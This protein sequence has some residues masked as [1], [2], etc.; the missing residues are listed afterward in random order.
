NKHGQSLKLLDKAIAIEPKEALFH[1]AKGDIFFNRKQFDYAL[2]AYDRAIYL[3]DNYFYFYEKR[4]LIHKQLGNHA[5]A[6]Q[7]LK[8]S[9]DLL[10]TAIAYNELGQFALKSG[11][12]S[13]AKHF[14]IKAASSNSRA[15]KS[16]LHS[17]TKLD[18]PDNPQKYVQV[19]WKENNKNDAVFKIYNLSP[20]PLYNISL[21]INFH[22]DKGE[23]YYLPI[24]LPDV[25]APKKNVLFSIDDQTIGAKYQH[26]I[27]IDVISAQA[28][29]QR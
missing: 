11:D 25:I 6:I 16:A 9:S 23:R 8:R 24:H 10:P 14:F 18:I 15:G 3:N 29:T 1:G 22:N 5:N 13:G 26:T 2:N 4:G 27:T 17:Y 28:V 19:R 12:T 20:L 7:D 21:K